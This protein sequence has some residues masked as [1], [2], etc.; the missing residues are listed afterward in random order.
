MKLDLTT[1][2][3]LCL[4]GYLIYTINSYKSEMGVLKNDMGNLVRMVVSTQEP[5]QEGPPPEPT[6]PL[7]PYSSGPPQ[8]QQRPIQRPAPSATAA[9]QR[10]NPD[11]ERVGPPPGFPSQDLTKLFE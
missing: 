2:G 6:V 10:L 5:V 11:P 4:V 8:R 1:I 9:V 3:L 7:R